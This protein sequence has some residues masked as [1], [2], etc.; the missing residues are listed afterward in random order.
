MLT[1]MIAA[2]VGSVAA[3]QP[4][5]PDSREQAR[6]IAGEASAHYNLGRFQEALAGYE[7]AYELYPAH[8]LLFNLGQCH[9]E[10]GTHER[11]IFFFE[12]YLEETGDSPNRELVIDLIA[13]SR[14][15]LARSAAER[16]AQ[17]LPSSEA[18][19][20]ER[21][22]QVEALRELEEARAALEAAREDGD[23]TRDEERRTYEAALEQLE[24]A[25]A[26][27]AEARYLAQ[28]RADIAL[29]AWHT[30]RAGGR[31]VAAHYLAVAAQ[32]AVDDLAADDA[33]RAE[34]QPWADD[35]QQAAD[36]ANDAARGA[37]DM[38]AA[39][40]AGVVRVSFAMSLTEEACS[41]S[42][43]DAVAA[44]EAARACFMVVGGLDPVCGL[45]PAAPAGEA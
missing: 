24:E 3:A 19:E 31:A 20:A 7:R 45:D 1:A 25:R 28:L 4:S 9:R 11:A 33:V 13:E 5:E 17:Q 41:K 43:A 8:G 2:S 23:R 18:L 16:E 30:A 22:R 42:D 29:A 40:L 21:A 10:L 39:V 6:A 35:A 12:R 44:G 36:D 15:A 38:V 34:A 27:L 37:T 26:E 14:A 32:L